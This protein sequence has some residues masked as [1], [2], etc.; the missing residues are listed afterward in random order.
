MTT[1]TSVTFRVGHYGQESLTLDEVTLRENGKPAM[2]VRI[3]F[4]LQ[5]HVARKLIHSHSEV[6]L[7]IDEA[8]E[9]VDI[10]DNFSK[11]C[12]EISQGSRIL[13][14]EYKIREGKA[15][16]PAL[17]MELN[18]PPANPD[19]KPFRAISS[20]NQ[21][22]AYSIIDFFYGWVDAIQRKENEPATQK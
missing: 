7:T 2:K 15:A 17:R 6:F 8:Q 22:T 14:E 13:F 19:G 3:D 5:D 1:P 9:M 11:G 16:I 12:I 18:I 20:I 4:T 10:L 21:G